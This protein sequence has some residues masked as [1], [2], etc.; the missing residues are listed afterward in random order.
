MIHV[1][2]LSAL[3]FDLGMDG[4]VGGVKT[5]DGPKG[6]YYFAVDSSKCTQEEIIKCIADNLGNGKVENTPVE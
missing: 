1:N 5:E 2:D 3:V 4:N 6:K